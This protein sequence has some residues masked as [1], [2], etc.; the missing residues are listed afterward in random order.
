MSILDL[1]RE[2]SRE[3][4]LAELTGD[5][6]EVLYIEIPTVVACGRYRRWGFSHP[7]R[8]LLRRRRSVKA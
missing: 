3:L 6:A 8:I 5:V 7:L 1:I 2:R 4:T